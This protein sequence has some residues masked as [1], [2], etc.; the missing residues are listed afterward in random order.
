MAVH[1][2][3][4]LS[5]ERR[6]AFKQRAVFVTAARALFKVT[7]HTLHCLGDFRTGKLKFHELGKVVKAAIAVHSIRFAAGNEMKK[8][9]GLF[10]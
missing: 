4:L 2:T 5:P 6:E 10:V 8:Q 1:R 7:L 3:L 9:F